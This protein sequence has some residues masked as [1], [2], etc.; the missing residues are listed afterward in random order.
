MNKNIIKIILIIM[1]ITLC[2]CARNNGESAS[3]GLK[4]DSEVDESSS[5]ESEDDSNKEDSVQGDSQRKA[6]FISEDNEF[7]RKIA[8]NPIDINY[9]IDYEAPVLQIYIDLVDKCF[10]WDNQIDYTLAALENELDESIYNELKEVVDLWHEY[11]QEELSINGSLYGGDGF[12]M[13]SMYKPISAEMVSEKAKYF[14]CILSS[15]EYVITSD[16]SFAE[17]GR[18]DSEGAE[19]R[20][21]SWMFC[22]E[23]I[24]DFE[25]AIEDYSIEAMD[26]D[27][28]KKLINETAGSIEERFGHEFSKHAD[29]CLALTERLYRIESKVLQDE[30]CCKVIRD[31][32][33][34][35]MVT[36]LLYIKY[37]IDEYPINENAN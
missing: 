26:T 2:G 21:E 24:D 18:T 37:L 14:A 17:E 36:E 9:I 12:I 16:I 4:S 25:D 22:P 33:L 1:L 31:N 5:M 3:V 7:Y 28:L 19:Y 8:E 34:R 32:R 13:G 6:Y 10:V 30:E 15:I 23:Y 29:K 27:N 20:I 35:L 11:F